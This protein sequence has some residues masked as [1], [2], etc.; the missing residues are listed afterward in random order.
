[1]NQYIVIDPEYGSVVLTT[2]SHDTFA[3]VLSDNPNL[4]G[5]TVKHVLKDLRTIDGEYMI[6]TGRY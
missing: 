4:K 5:Y 3:S 6:P 1:M 2:F